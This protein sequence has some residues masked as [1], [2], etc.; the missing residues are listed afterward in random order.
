MSPAIEVLAYRGLHPLQKGVFVNLFVHCRFPPLD[1][2]NEGC[3]LLACGV[4]RPVLVVSRRTSRILG[5]PLLGRPSWVA[6]RDAHLRVL[7]SSREFL[8]SGS[9]GPAAQSPLLR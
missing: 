3:G 7:L 8:G 2:L 9:L 5:G 1:T 4:R 6:W